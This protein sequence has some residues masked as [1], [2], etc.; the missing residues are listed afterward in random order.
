MILKSEDL[1]ILLQQFCNTDC[2]PDRAIKNMIVSFTGP[3]E[4]GDEDYRQNGQSACSAH[5]PSTSKDSQV[6][7]MALVAGPS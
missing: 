5:L 4:P 7:T 1:D 3:G 2:Q 6:E